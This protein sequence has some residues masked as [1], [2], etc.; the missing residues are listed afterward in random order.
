MFQTKQ[1]KKTYWALTYNA[2]KIES[3]RIISH[4]IKNPRNNTVKAFNKEKENSK[5]KS[6]IIQGAKEKIPRIGAP[7]NFNTSFNFIHGKF[8]LLSVNLTLNLNHFRSF[9]RNSKIH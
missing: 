3:D 2:P 5:R 8:R 4:L 9:S 6:H 7:F 1:V